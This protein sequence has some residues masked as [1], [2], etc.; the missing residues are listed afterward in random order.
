MK[1]TYGILVIALL[2]TIFTACKKDI[3]DDNNAKNDLVSWW[4]LAEVSASMTPV[5]TYDP[6]N[7]NVLRINPNDTYSYWK[8][9]QVIEQGNYSIVADGSVETETGL[10]NL[11]DK[12][13]NRFEVTNV[14]PAPNPVTVVK[15]FFYV[16]GDKL[17][18]IG[19]NFQVDGGSLRVYRRATPI[20]ID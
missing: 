1:K 6:G 15:T 20:A 4:E 19:G 11:K 7:G 5:Q 9:D 2:I 10:I 16:A 8:N 17:Y 14:T 18:M 12:Y 13:L 3:G